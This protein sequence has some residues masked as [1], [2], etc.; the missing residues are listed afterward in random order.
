M[1]E[2]HREREDWQLPENAEVQL[3]LFEDVEEPSDV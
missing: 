1:S 2:R 3:D